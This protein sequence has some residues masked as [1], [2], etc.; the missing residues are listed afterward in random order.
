MKKLPVGDFLAIALVLLFALFSALPFFFQKKEGVSV[1]VTTDSSS[2][3]LPLSEGREQVIL[4]NGHTLTLVIEAGQ[5][6][7]KEADCPD[8]ICVGHPISKSGQT[9]ICVPAHVII[10]ITGE[11]VGHDAVVG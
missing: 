7:V 10:E 2:F 9:I 4:S 5:A 8:K 6:F 11:E 1:K 3:T